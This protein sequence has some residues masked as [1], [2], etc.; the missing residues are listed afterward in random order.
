[1]REVYKRHITTLARRVNVFNK[2][3]YAE[4]PTIMAW[5]VVASPAGRSSACV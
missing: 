2:K 3:V 4:D 1:M 5:C